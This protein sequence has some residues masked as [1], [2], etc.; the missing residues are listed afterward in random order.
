MFYKNR[1]SQF[2]LVVSILL[3]MFFNIVNAEAEFCTINIHK[4]NKSENRTVFLSGGKAWNLFQTYLKELESNNIKVSIRKITVAVWDGKAIRDFSFSWRD[5][6]TGQGPK[7]RWERRLRDVDALYDESSLKNAINQKWDIV[8]IPA[9]TPLPPPTGGSDKGGSEKETQR[10]SDLIP[11]EAKLHLQ[12]G[13]NYVK[14]RDYENAIKEFTL[15]I[16]KHPD[17]AVAYSNRA[18]AYMQQKKFNKA[19]D[20][21]KKASEI[22]PNDPMVHYNFTSLYSLQNQ[23][24]RALDSLDK[25]LA[26]GFNDYD[27]LRK[28]TDLNNLRKHPEYKKVLEKYKVFIK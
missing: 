19:M 26:L 11:V 13:M 16:N 14:L 4:E 24:D 10:V 22:A 18:I 17:Y 7:E 28:D 2:E 3:L 12:Q 6:I 20:D 15:A 8:C 5:W 27:S 25:A 1:K 23:L 9:A 21:L